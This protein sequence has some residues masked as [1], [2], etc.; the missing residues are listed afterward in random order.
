MENCIATDR[1]KG[2]IAFSIPSL[3]AVVGFLGF[4]VQKDCNAQISVAVIS[5][6]LT[7]ISCIGVCFTASLWKAWA[8]D[9]TICKIEK[10]EDFDFFTAIYS[11]MTLVTT[12]ETIALIG[13][14]S[15]HC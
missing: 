9:R 1:A 6:A 13:Q 11:L 12:I 2:V 14:I 3:G 8:S 7:A 4:V 10:K 5:T 15:N